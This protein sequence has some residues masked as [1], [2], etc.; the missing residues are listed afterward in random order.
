MRKHLLKDM[1][2]VEL[3]DGFYSES[4]ANKPIVTQIQVPVKD[5]TPYQV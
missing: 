3:E 1:F 2:I 5:F 4:S